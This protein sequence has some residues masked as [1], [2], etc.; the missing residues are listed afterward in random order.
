MEVPLGL[1]EESE[2]KFHHVFLFSI[3]KMATTEIEGLPVHH[4]GAAEA[5]GGR[6]FV[7]QDK[8]CLRVVLHERAGEGESRGT[9]TEDAIVYREHVEREGIAISEVCRETEVAARTGR[10][11]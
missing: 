11:G 7:E 3:Q 4:G 6:C 9:G 1:R 8:G 5:S 2:Q 10:W